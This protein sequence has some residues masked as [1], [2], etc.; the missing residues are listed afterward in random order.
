[1]TKSLFLKKLM[2][3]LDHYTCM[4]IYHKDY[5]EPYIHIVRAVHDGFIELDLSNDLEH[6]FW[7]DIEQFLLNFPA[8]DFTKLEFKRYKLDLILK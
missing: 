6:S 7:D 4:V 5:E 3:N 8:K 1:M 2:M